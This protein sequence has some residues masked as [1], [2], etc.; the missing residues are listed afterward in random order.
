MVRLEYDA[1]DRDVW[2]PNRTRELSTVRAVTLQCDLQRGHGGSHE[3]PW[4]GGVYASMRV[5][6]ETS[7]PCPTQH[8]DALRDQMRPCGLLEGHDGPHGYENPIMWV[9]NATDSQQN[10]ER[11]HFDLPRADNDPVST[12]GHNTEDSEM[13]RCTRCNTRKN[14]DDFR[15]QPS[16]GSY[17]SWCRECERAHRRA[18][19]RRSATR[20][21]TRGRAFGVEVELTGPSR[22]I[23]LSALRGIGIDATS[24]G[25]RASR[26][27]N[28]ELKSDCSVGGNGLE[29]VSPKLYGDAG[30]EELGRVLAA[31]NGVGASVNRTC[32]IHV[33]VDMTGRDAQTIKNAIRPFL[34]SQD[35][36][37]Q[38]VAPSRRS[39]HY[40]APWSAASID[41][42][43]AATSLQQLTNIGPRGFVNMGAYTRH[44]TVEFRSHG[45]ST[46]F[47]KV[48]AWVRLILAGVKHGEETYENTFGDDARTVCERL[49]MSVDDTNAL[50]RFVRAA[51]REEANDY[52]MVV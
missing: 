26:G 6:S 23:L 24:T 33:H 12:P 2:A 51:E 15:F 50:T 36:F 25:Y 9:G 34:A 32:G 27:G 35:A 37:F 14:T 13:R 47:A 42:F 3:G 8:Y 39:N 18:N 28:W 49:G 5:D 52:E 30:I 31:I 7:N 40:S 44:S 1:Y 29:L 19:P 41:Q 38:M 43:N 22:E 48:G 16:I 45:G 11:L 17:H 21:S 10:S 20:R 4:S 46:N